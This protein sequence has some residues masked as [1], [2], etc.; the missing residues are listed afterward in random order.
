MKLSEEDGKLFYKLWLP[1][2]DYVNEKRS[3]N[4][5]LHDIHLAKTLNPSEVKE[6]A[7]ALW[8]ETTLIDTYLHENAC[9]P[10]EEK[11]IIQSW[12]RCVTGRFI[13]ERILKKG[14]ILIS[15][16][17]EDVY[18]VSGIVSTWEEMFGYARL[19]IIIN[20]AL[21]PFRDVIIPD[22]LIQTYNVI[23]GGNMSRSFKDFYM[24]AKNNGNIL[25]RL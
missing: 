25:R 23:I 22:G 5:D 6:V 10:D 9:I 1:L 3:V 2:L 11:E 15:S 21:I 7:D 20:A 24:H 16:D 4:P 13:L 19:P 8:N 12:K 17:N 18:Q 14:A